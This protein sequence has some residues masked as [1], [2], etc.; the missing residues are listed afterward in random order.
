MPKPDQALELARTCARL[1]DERKGEGIEL[2][3]VR[4]ALKIADYFVIVTGKNSRHLRAM[5]DELRRAARTAGIR[6]PREEG[7]AE[8]GRWVLVD[9]GDVVVHLFSADKRSYYDL[10]SLWHA[11]RVVVRMQ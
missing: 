6:V 7:R 9:F 5:A 1:C 10:E 4:D 11:G 3:D 8:D 2:L